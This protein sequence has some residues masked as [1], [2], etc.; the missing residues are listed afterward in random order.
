MRLRGQ[1]ARFGMAKKMAHV[2]VI[3][4]L[5]NK[6]GYIGRALDSVFSQSYQDFEVV[7]VDDGSNDGGA[8]IVRG[9]KDRRLRLV[10]QANTGPGAARNRG[11]SESSAGLL[12]FLDADDEWM[13]EFLQT[14]LNKLES[15]PDCDLTA[16]SYYLGKQRTDITPIFERRGITAG[17]WRL[18][19]DIS[20]EE[21]RHAIGIFTSECVLCKRGAIEKYGG[22]YSKNR[23]NYGED[24]YL[25]LQVMFNH[26][27]Y[28]ILEPLVW[29][30]S[31]VSE[32]G[33][34]RACQHPLEPFL[35]EPELLR[36]HCPQQYR[37]L[38]ELFL[39]RFALATAHECAAGNGNNKNVD[40]LVAAFPLMKEFRWEYFKLKLKKLQPK[41]IPFVRAVKKGC[42]DLWGFCTGKNCKACGRLE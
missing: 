15:N 7:V 37:Q 30:H 23:C 29:Y 36:S 2:G 42:F 28:R 13:A 6:A 10:R 9:Y 35:T 22:F 16:C 11:V 31:E 25:W 41:L 27:V 4:P 8:E 39:T 14:S 17:P 40:Y 19:A 18:R 3:I 1:N 34:G 12:A 24:Y 5:Y 20:P 26:R 33:P 38:L 21:L 32:L